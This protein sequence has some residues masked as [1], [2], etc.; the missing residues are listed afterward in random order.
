METKVNYAAVG[1][2]V[3][4]LGAVMVGA[5]L[6]LASGGAFQKK[7]DIYRAKVNESVAGL[8]LNAPFKFNGV[9]I[10]KVSAIQLDRSNPSQVLLTFSIEQGAPIKTDTIAVLN[11][12]GLTGIAYVELSGGSPS[13]PLLNSTVTDEYPMIQT[14]PSLSTR[15]ENML[16]TVLTSI[17][18]TTANLNAILSKENSL[19]FRNMLNDV[20]AVAHTVASRKQ[21]LDASMINMART[22]EN[23]A[24]VTAQ[25]GPVVSGIGRSADALEIMAHEAGQ[26]SANAG[27]T[28]GAIGEDVQ[29]FTTETLPEV[30]RLMGETS[31][32]VSSLR[33]LTEQTE[34]NPASLLFGHQPLPL[35]PGEFPVK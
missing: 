34:R 2:F 15:L 28:V 13:A 7:Y 5:V 24:R 11:S 22:F 10:G 16:S 32:L 1:I 25:M 6:W 9:D 31:V 35:G 14:R 33:R 18:H 27:R 8:N 17:D 12:Q 30:E 21:T 20:A 4:V 3:I 26:A 19:A 23:S 29:R